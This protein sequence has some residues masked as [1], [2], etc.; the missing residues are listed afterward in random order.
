MRWFKHMTNSIDDEKISKLVDEC[1]LEGYGFFW[2]V[3][4]MIAAQVDDDGK[5]YC[6]YSKRAWCNKLAINHQTWSKLIASCEQAGLFEV[7]YSEQEGSKPRA[8]SEQ[9]ASKKGASEEQ[10]GS[11]K[12]A[13]QHQIITVKSPNILKY[14]DEWSRKK[15]KNS[16]VSPEKLR[17]DSGPSR[18]RVPDTDTETETETDIKDNPHPFANEGET[19]G[20][21]PDP[22][23]EL[24]E[25]DG[26]VPPPA[27][28]NP[29]MRKTRRRAQ[30]QRRSAGSCIADLRAAMETY[31]VNAE[32]RQ[33]LEGFRVMR[34]RL[35][36][37]L[38]ARAFQLTCAELDK[39][40]GNDEALKVKIL[41]QSVQRGWQGVFALK[42]D[43]GMQQED[44][45]A[46]AI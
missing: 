35:R 45:W 19:C 30:E 27:G 2:R 24:G 21:S 29:E 42:S 7:S 25:P 22:S 8:R 6:S 38:T 23:C 9:G 44:R 31:T 12:G 14:R 33:A 10:E 20:F 36:K 4:E 17:S 13:S 28:E 5:N 18:A 3:L 43:A 16:G 34:E 26:K 32:L 39:L 37:P 41:D 15:A 11:K 40:A 1:G 46:G